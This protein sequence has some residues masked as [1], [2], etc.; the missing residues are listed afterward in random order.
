MLLGHV[1]CLLQGPLV[2]VWETEPNITDTK[3][4][5]LG[6]MRRERNVFQMKKSV[7]LL[8]RSDVKTGNLPEDDDHKAD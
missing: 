6:N 4:S 2:Q 1:G 8:C 3:G 5:N 7:L